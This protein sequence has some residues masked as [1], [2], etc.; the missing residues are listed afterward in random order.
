MGK[1]SYMI[2]RSSS[3]VM[4]YGVFDCPKIKPQQSKI[5][6]RILYKLMKISGD[7]L[8]ISPG[9]SHGKVRISEIWEESSITDKEDEFTEN[10]KLV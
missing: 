7:S 2:K 9:I 5:I 4:F 3:S 1:C 6:V 10:K 8:T